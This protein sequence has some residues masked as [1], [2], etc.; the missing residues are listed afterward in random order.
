VPRSRADSRPGAARSP[1]DGLERRVHP[2]IQIAV[3]VNFGS[4]HNFYSGRTRDISAGGLFIE[5]DVPLPV[6]MRITVDVQLLKTKVRGDA[7]VVWVLLDDKGQTVGMGVRFMSLPASTRE[8]IEAFMGLRE[9]MLFE[10]EPD[11]DPAG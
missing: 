8:R 3:V 4:A 2:R 11:D 9:A 5:T 10:M 6:G 7:E 1:A